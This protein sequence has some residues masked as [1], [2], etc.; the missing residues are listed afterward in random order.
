MAILDRCNPI[1]IN[2]DD[3]SSCSLTRADIKAMTP[4]DF[5]AQDT[6][7]V[8]MDQIIAQEKELR[9]TGVQI[10][11]LHDLLLSRMR[12]GSRGVI[13]KDQFNRSVIA[14]FSLIPQRSTVNAAYFEVEAG[15]ADP[16]AGNNGI[17]SNAWQV[18][19]KNDQSTFATSLKDLETYFLKEN[20]VVV[21]W[22]DGTTAHSAQFRIEKT[23]NADAG[24]VEK[25][26][27]TLVPNYTEAGFDGLTAA[28][29]KPWQPTAGVLIP[30]AN[31]I[32]NYESWCNQYPTELPGKLRDFWWHT[33]RRT[34]AYNEEYVKALNAPL[35]SDYFKKFRMLP[36]ADQRKR[37]GVMFQRDFMN[38]VFYGDR[39]NE[40]QTANGYTNLPKVLDPADPSCVMEYKA[41]T[42]GYR[43]QL[44]ECSRVIDEE[45]GA[46]D[47]D[48]IKDKLYE[49]K[50]Y[51]EAV[52]GGTVDRI[53]GMT[54]R[55]T[56][57]L[58]QQLMFDYYKKKYNTD[59]TRFYRPGEP[60]RA[61]G[62]VLWDFMLFEFP[63]EGFELALMRDT[64]FDDH[65]AAFPTAQKSRG[66][67][68]W[69]PDWTD[70]H[71]DVTDTK[72]VSR[73]TNEADELYRCVIQPNVRHYQ[74]NSQTIQV[75]VE[76]PNRHLIFE[77]FSGACPTITYDGCTATDG[78]A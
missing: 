18:T 58:V 26:K 61:N 47:F 74:L 40:N 27:L 50:R 4:S 23:V 20:N 14:P 65:L 11:G 62:Q 64:Y 3:A 76:D 39:I 9:M 2:V 63:E 45:N 66:R 36:L 22:K 34:F 60:L 13:G 10:K 77:N 28:N 35:T 33:M 41:N 57:G 49:V 54:D 5:E 69:F 44:N 48:V 1:L 72:S 56:F 31:S 7:E 59:I 16:S 70:V 17:P 42:L 73:K 15:A 78:S 19:I 12:P 21:L 25:A 67:Q 75:Q 37:Q 30:L 51:R 43:T 53:D 52:T 32:S 6:Q 71:I 55:T 29:K 68:L 46:L 24:G 8:R 38:T